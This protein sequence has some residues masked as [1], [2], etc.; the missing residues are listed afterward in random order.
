MK[1]DKIMKTGILILVLIFLMASLVITGTCATWPTG[2]WQSS[3]PEEQGM[4]SKLLAEGLD[5][6]KE[7]REEYHLHS[8]LVIRHGYI[9]ADVYF[10][11]FA[12][13]M[14]HDLASVTKSF[15]A[16]LL[17]IAIDKDYIE[18]VQQPVLDFF[19]ERTIAN[20]DA[21]KEAITVEDLLTMRSGFECINRPTEVTLFQMMES[22]DW[23]QFT[24]DLP[25]AEAPGTR[26]IYCSSNSHLL[27]PKNI[28][29]NLWAYLM[30]PGLPTHR[31]T[32]TVGVICT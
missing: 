2:G 21:D 13:G 27:L 29:L 7:H 18:S 14:M 26:F 6:L 15:T 5:F 30:S 12:P 32:T 10:H 8:L 20:L 11:P 23:I 3:N 19:P 4:D 28:S 9:V 25:M 24:L 16:T 17:G 31:G 22:P 1:G